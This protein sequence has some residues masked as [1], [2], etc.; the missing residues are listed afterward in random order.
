MK[1]NDPFRGL[2]PDYKPPFAESVYN[3]LAMG[4]ALGIG[5]TMLLGIWKAV[6]LVL[7]LF[8]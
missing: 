8:R 3:A 1:T 6:E 2:T 7:W 5:T 4:V